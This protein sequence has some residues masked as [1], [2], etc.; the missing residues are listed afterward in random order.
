MTAKK[1]PKFPFRDNSFALSPKQFTRF[2][3]VFLDYSTQHYNENQKKLGSYVHVTL[4]ISIAVVLH[5]KNG[6]LKSSQWHLSLAE[7]KTW[8]KDASMKLKAQGG[9][10]KKKKGLLKIFC[11]SGSCPFSLGMQDDIPLYFSTRFGS[12]YQ[13]KTTVI[14]LI[15]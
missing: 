3:E 13:C 2:G 11:K 1:H 4:K 5:L 8:W 15:F 9:K 10:K 14:G 7:N 12:S 6:A